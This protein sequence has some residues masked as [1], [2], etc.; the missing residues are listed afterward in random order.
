MY[1][2]AGRRKGRSL[3]KGAEMMSEKCIQVQKIDIFTVQAKKGGREKF[4]LQSKLYN[5]FCFLR[6]KM[7]ANLISAKYMSETKCHIL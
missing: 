1:T 4:S 5:N 2:G 6:F 7:L 3:N